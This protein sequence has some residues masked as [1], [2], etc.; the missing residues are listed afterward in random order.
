MPQYNRVH[1][2]SRCY[3]KLGNTDFKHI[4]NSHLFFIL[5]DWDFMET[6]TSRQN[7]K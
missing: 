2:N 4:I 5:L 7:T 3:E 6:Q 1:E